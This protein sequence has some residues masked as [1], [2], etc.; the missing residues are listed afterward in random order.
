MTKSR[1]I[2]RGP[3]QTAMP[4]AASAA[5]Q[6]R[7]GTSETCVMPMTLPLGTSSARGSLRR[8]GHGVESLK[9]VDQVLDHLQP[10]RPEIRVRSIEAERRE[11]FLMMLGPA[12]PEHGG[13]A[14]GEP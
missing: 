10:H 11:Q 12:R 4:A 1:A 8:C 13:K 7:I 6:S 9:L 5:T 3:R 14:L 2:G